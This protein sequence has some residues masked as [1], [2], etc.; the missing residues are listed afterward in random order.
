MAKTVAMLHCLLLAAPVWAQQDCTRLPMPSLC[1]PRGPFRTEM[2]RNAGMD[3]GLLQRETPT[4]LLDSHGK[5]KT[6]LSVGLSSAPRQAVTGQSPQPAPH[7]I[8]LT[9][10]NWRPLTS[11]EKLTLFDRDLLHWETH[12]SLLLD[13][14]IASAVGDREFLG[15]GA[16]GFFSIYGLDAAD[17]LNFTFF[18]AYLFPTLFHQ[19]PRYIP[20]DHGT[21]R[22]RLL[23]AV[24]RIAVTRGDSGRSEINRSKILGTILATSISSSYYAACGANVGVGGNFASVGINL[25]SD[26]A[27]DILKEFWPDAARKLNLSLWIR[28]LVRTSIRDRIRIG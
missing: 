13:S 28:R 9:A 6:F 11:K 2:F 25:G 18:N 8:E 23:Y 3:F 17:E 27:F 21:F 7:L 15:T 14:A 5:R 24:S 12:A 16:R 10:A 1:N 4:L 26:A 19:D 22:Q 20:R